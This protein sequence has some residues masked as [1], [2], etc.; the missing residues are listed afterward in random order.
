[1]CNKITL[2]YSSIHSAARQVTRMTKAKRSDLNPIDKM[3]RSSYS[4]NV[5]IALAAEVPEVS[6]PHKVY[7]LINTRLFSTQIRIPNVFIVEAFIIESSQ[8]DL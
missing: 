2:R 3:E 8:H 1:M 4:S 6:I 5:K 7:S